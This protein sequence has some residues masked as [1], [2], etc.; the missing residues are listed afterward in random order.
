[1]HKVDKRKFWTKTEKSEK[2]KRKKTKVIRSRRSQIVMETPNILETWRECF[3]DK[4]ST[5][6]QEIQ[7]ETDEVNKELMQS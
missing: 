2:A 4:F 3:E 5:Q 6:A 7:I 1:M